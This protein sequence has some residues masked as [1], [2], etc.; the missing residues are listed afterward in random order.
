LC[1]VYHGNQPKEEAGGGGVESHGPEE[2]PPP[3]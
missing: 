3:G 2:A 1:R